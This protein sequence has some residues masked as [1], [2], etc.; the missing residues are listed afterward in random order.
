MPIR[1]AETGEAARIHALVSETIDQ[2]YVGHYTPKIVDSFHKFHDFD[3]IMS[4]IIA[5][6]C[7]IFGE[8]GEILGTVTADGAH[9]RRL[10]VSP[11]AQ[12]KGVGKELLFF[13]ESAAYA[14][15]ETFCE[16]DSSVP[17]ES[18]YRRLGYTLREECEDDFYGVNVRWKV[19]EY[20]LPRRT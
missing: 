4:D 7:Y 3:S 12:G 16:V 11:R 15:G 20:A 14:G 1:I 8:N 17:A 9:V 19:F 13:A 6:K 18:F 10:F 2:C 5:E